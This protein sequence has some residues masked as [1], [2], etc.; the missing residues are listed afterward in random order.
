[1]DTYILDENDCPC[2]A[3]FEKYHEW[4]RSL[5]E[6]IQTGVGFTLDST[7]RDGIRVSTVYLGMDHGFDN[8]PP[9]LW[10]TMV[11]GMDDEIMRRYTSRQQAE[12]GYKEICNE[13]FNMAY[14][15]PKKPKGGKGGKGK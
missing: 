6:E 8:G 1:M 7:E 9:V 13:V 12:E 10:E 11:F 14:T 5:P 2:L 3:T 4:R 15:T